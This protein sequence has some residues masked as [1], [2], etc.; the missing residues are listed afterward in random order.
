RQLGLEDPTTTD[1]RC[2]LL[3]TQYRM[4][5]PIRAVVSDTFY[6]GLLIDAPEIV[7]RHGTIDL[8]LVDTSNYGI[9]EVGPNGDESFVPNRSETSGKS[10]INP[11]H[12]DLVGRIV[13][14]LHEE[15]ETDIAIITP[16]N[17]QTRLVR[18]AL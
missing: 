3:R 15:R 12:A 9:I 6:A 2:V 11:V 16:F 7:K 18:D 4:A 14:T 17:A 1:P 8:Q 13:R 5:P 10:R